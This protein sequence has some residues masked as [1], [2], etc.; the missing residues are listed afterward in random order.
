MNPPP[1]LDFDRQDKIQ[2]ALKFFLGYI[3]GYDEFRPGQDG[4]IRKALSRS[5]TLGI[6]P[7]GSGKSLCYQMACLLQ[8]CISFVVCPI[9]S[10]IQDQELNSHE[11]GIDRVGRIDSQMDRT[12]KNEVLETFGNGKYFFVWIS[13]ER[14]Q[15]VDFRRRLSELSSRRNFGYAVI[16]EV[17]CLS[18]WGHDFRVS[19]LKLYGTIKKYCP[20]AQIIA[21]TATA[22]RNVLED[23][24]S[25]LEITKENV[26]TSTS[27]DRPEL[28]FHIVQVREQEREEK[29]DEVLDGIDAHFQETEGI[30]SVFEPRDKDSVCGVI[31]SNVKNSSA[32]P[33]ASCEGVLAHLRKRGIQADSYHAGRNEDRSTIQKEFLDNRFTVMSATKAFGMGVNKKNVRYTIHNGLPWSIEAFYQEAGRAGRDPAR[34]E[35]ECYILYSNE[36]HQDI[37]KRLFQEATSVGEIIGLQSKLV[38]DLGTL[39][40]LWSGNHEDPEIERRAIVEVF[41]WL[42]R[43]RDGNG[44]VTVPQNLVRELMSPAAQA[45]ASRR[46]KAEGRSVKAEIRIGTQDALYKL[47]ILGIVVDWTVDYR[48]KT[49]DVETYKIDGSSEGFV[50]NKL[51]EYIR[52]HNPTFSFDSKS[53]THRKY[54]ETYKQAPKGRKLIGLIDVLLKWTNDNIVFSR[55]R[56]IGNMLDLCTET[57]EGKIT[58]QRLHEYLNS[59]FRLDTESNDQLDAIV[60]DSTHIE[61]WIRLFTTYELTDDPAVQNEVLKD[62]KEIESI[63]A[64]CDRYRESFHANI[65]LEWATMV[66]K[67]LSGSFSES[68]VDGQFSFVSSEISEYE[69]LDSD[70]LFVK[71]LAL[72]ADA[73]NDSKDAFG[74]AVVKHAPARALQTY[75]ELNDMATLTHLVNMADSRLKSKWKRSS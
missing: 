7:T 51:E 28:K 59:Y 58:E 37:V 63:A 29:L 62:E 71:T 60:R 75:K 23:L 43:R 27:L 15:T 54:I 8:P 9:I 39:F 69:E 67:L 49:F 22:S 66:A 73:S 44:H 5:A 42:Q 3:F 10:L 1:P 46:A 12:D 40:F 2:G 20:E 41:K 64:L 53:A 13:P 36:N 16:D 45:R 33:L 24:L 65:G 52:R 47:A 74:A 32:R 55:R 72:L 4:V 50:K 21:L 34:N 19:Y 25:E 57:A 11:F 14:F 48:T 68:D 17:H 35:S 70:G 26:Q 6:L 30:E 31:F 56:A 38:G 18:E 61:T